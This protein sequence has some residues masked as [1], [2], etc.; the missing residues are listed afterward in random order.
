MKSLF[1]KKKAGSRSDD[2]KGDVIGADDK[3]L[4]IIEG[5]WLQS[6]TFK[7]K[8]TGKKQ[9]LWDY[10][11]RKNDVKAKPIDNPLPSDSR[12]R[13]DI[14]WLAKENLQEAANWK[15]RLERKQ[16]YEAKLR[17]EGPKK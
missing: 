15:D 6:I 3:V 11:D 8:S 14:I 17:K 10:E 1:V 4:G 13:E 16:R 2:L 5:S 7:D 9:L 12:Y